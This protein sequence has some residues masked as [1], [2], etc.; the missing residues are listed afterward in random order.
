MLAVPQAHHEQRKGMML[1]VGWLSTGRGEGSRRLLSF[2]MERVQH[3]KLPLD[4][5]FVFCNREP[6]EHEGT[7]AF[8]AQ[9]RS[10]GIPLV[11]H[12]G[13]RFRQRVGQIADHREAY[14]REVL[15]RI[16]PYDADVLVLAG[17]MLIVSSVLCRRYPMLNLHPALP[18]G[19][20]GTW[21]EVIWELI[22]T[23]ASRAGGMVHLAIEEVDRGPVLAYYAFPIQGP[24]W[25]PFW[26]EATGRTVAE[27]K[28][29]A[30]EDLP[31]FRAIR[32]GQL[33]RE[34]Y[35]VAETLRTITEGRVRLEPGV[36]KDAE[37][38]PVP[39]VDLSDDIEAALVRDRG[40][41]PPRDATTTP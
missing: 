24:E 33:L 25:H 20:I 19:P 29:T 10:Y 35:L 32:Q 9:A 6:G 38:R 4:V 12:S 5:R 15:E 23:H 22:E 31:L 13:R 34:P 14:D 17:Y 21:Q 26:K 16:A 11:C 41:V 37:G 30:G 36:V 28:T 8:F 1:K 27:I 40:M 2:V 39:G 3:G 18:S 7:D